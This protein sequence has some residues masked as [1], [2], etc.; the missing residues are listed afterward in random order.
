M[1][2]GAFEIELKLFLHTED[3]VFGCLGDAKLHNSLMVCSASQ[4]PRAS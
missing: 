3:R 2:K 1:N 4:L